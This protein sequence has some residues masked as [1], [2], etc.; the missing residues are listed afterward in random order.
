MLQIEHLPHDDYEQ[1]VHFSDDEFHCFIAL[2]STKLGPALGGCRLKPYASEADALLDV[3][4]LAKGMTYKSSLAGLSLGGGKCVVMAEKAT[5]DIML[6]VG[7]AVN[8]FK[9]DYC[10]AEDVGTTLDDINVVAETTGHVVHLDGS[11]NTARSVFAAM[12]AAA[13]YLGQW[14]NLD[15]VPIWIQGLGKVGRD[16][17]M[18]LHGHN[19]LYVSDL[20]PDVVAQAVAAGAHEITESDRKFIAIYAPCALGQVIH[21]GNVHG[22]TYSI[23][24]G[25]A[26]N[27]L[28]DE[29]YADILHHNH[30]LWCPDYL[31]NAGGVI[32]AAGEIE[33]W[34]EEEVAERCDAVGIVMTNVLN[35]AEASKVSPL[36][37]ANTLAELRL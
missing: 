8:Y 1:V 36:A 31:V 10:T 30:V 20:R 34:S 12:Q 4:R 6:K 26:N 21:P 14:D 18:R 2:H 33:G 5:R 23:I 16:L 28:V 13:E 29:S 22:L 25:A 24:C 37:M 32:T 9:G 19:N 27:Q 3:L 35:L 11:P 7:D 17:A 15:G